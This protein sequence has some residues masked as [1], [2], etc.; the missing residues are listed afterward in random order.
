MAQHNDLGKEGEKESVNYLLKHGYEILEK[1]LS[2]F[3]S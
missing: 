1:K 2:I 3:K